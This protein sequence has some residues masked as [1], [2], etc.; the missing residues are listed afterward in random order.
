MPVEIGSFVAWHDMPLGRI[1][2]S[3]NGTTVNI[4]L[5]QG[6]QGVVCLKDGE[7]RMQ[8]TASFRREQFV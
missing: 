7:I 2:V 1:G 8:G 3:W 4:S 6:C 5:P